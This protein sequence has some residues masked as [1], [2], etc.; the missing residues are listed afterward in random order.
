[1]GLHSECNFTAMVLLRQGGRDSMLEQCMQRIVASCIS[2]RRWCLCGTC[3]LQTV[4]RSQGLV[5]VCVYAHAMH[6][7]RS[8][9]STGAALRA[10]HRLLVKGGICAVS[11]AEARR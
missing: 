1:M 8:Q 11:L 9:V 5:H 4:S 3:A 2:C 10:H 6:S 7:A